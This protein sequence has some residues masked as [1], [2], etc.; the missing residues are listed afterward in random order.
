MSMELKLVHLFF[1]FHHFLS[2]SLDLLLLISPLLIHPFRS[3]LWGF[4]NSILWLFFT[5][6][7]S[8]WLKWMIFLE[9]L[10][11]LRF[12]FHQSSLFSFRLLMQTSEQILL[13]F[14]CFTGSSL[15]HWTS[16]ASIHHLRSWTKNLRLKSAWIDFSLL[17]KDLETLYK[18]L[19]G[20]SLSVKSI[21]EGLFV[22]IILLNLKSEFLRLLVRLR[23]KCTVLKFLLLFL[24]LHQLRVEFPSWLWQSLVNMWVFSL[25]SSLILTC[26]GLNL[27]IWLESAVSKFISLLHYIIYYQLLVFLVSFSV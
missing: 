5:L 2:L 6:R 9:L 8:C 19:F 18:F 24:K 20:L 27:G 1:L 10:I 26:W 13:V 14:I 17:F 15:P 4:S 22:M 3:L 25:L 11:I 16:W 12:L 7:D 23:L 21:V